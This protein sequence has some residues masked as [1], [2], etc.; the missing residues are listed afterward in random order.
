M[1]VDYPPFS[2]ITG[3]SECC[4]PGQSAKQNR[5]DAFSGSVNE[6]IWNILP[7]FNTTHAFVNLGWE[8]SFSFQDQSKLSCDL[9]R[10][11]KVYTN[12]TLY[13]ITHPPTMR[14]TIDPTLAF[15]ATKLECDCNLLDRSVLSAGIPR[16]WY[17]D[18]GH[19]LSILMKNRITS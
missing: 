4:E 2:N 11:E 16:G 3:P 8:I 17:W 18:Q 1:N 7:L 19:V 12:I 5:T 14:N 6:T 9:R 10:F 15:D 13:L